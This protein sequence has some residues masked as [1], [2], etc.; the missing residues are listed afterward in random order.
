MPR[1]PDR[2][3]LAMG[4][5]SSSRRGDKEILISLYAVRVLVKLARKVIIFSTVLENK[6]CC[7]LRPFL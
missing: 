5:V 4:S 6:L 2:E 1:S 3:H 7:A